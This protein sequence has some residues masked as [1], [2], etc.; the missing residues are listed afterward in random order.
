MAMDEKSQE[1]MATEF[2]RGA[3]GPCTVADRAS[4]VDLYRAVYPQASVSEVAASI[5]DDEAAAWGAYRDEGG[6]IRV[7]LFIQSDGVVWLFAKPEECEMPEVKNAFLAL[8]RDARAAVARFGVSSLVVL[9]AANLQPL[10]RLLER[11]GYLT[12]EKTIARV[13]HFGEKGEVIRAN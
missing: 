2:P 6:E 3:V 10:G 13:M 4:L 1:A 9:H 8:A 11:E 12:K 7:A 5:K